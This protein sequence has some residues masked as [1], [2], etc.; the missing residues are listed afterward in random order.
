MHRLYAIGGFESRLTPE[1]CSTHPVAEI[2]SIGS[3]EGKDGV[4]GRVT[5][6]GSSNEGRRETEESGYWEDEE[7]GRGREKEMMRRE[8]RGGG[9]IVEDCCADIRTDRSD[10]QRNFHYLAVEI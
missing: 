8:E 10:Q 3:S 9:K 6:W 4:D 7:E 2:V 5:R 1:C